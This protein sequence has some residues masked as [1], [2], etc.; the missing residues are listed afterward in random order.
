[1]DIRLPPV[2]RRDLDGTPCRATRPIGEHASRDC[3][4]PRTEFALVFQLLVCTESTKE[5]FLESVGRIV[6][7]HAC[8]H[9]AVDLVSILAIHNFERRNV[10]AYKGKRLE[11]VLCEVYHDPQSALC[12]Q[13]S[14][15]GVVSDNG[16]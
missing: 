13:S 4:E 7:R 8:A 1:M 10:H 15:I 12:K 6:E 2:A 14:S 5:R 11:V 3:V 9:V 16:T